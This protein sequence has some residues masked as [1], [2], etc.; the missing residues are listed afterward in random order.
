MTDTVIQPGG[1]A[2]VGSSAA[3][4]SAPAPEPSVYTDGTTIAGNGTAGDRLRALGGGHAMLTVQL[5]NGEATTVLPG[6]AVTTI[7]GMARLASAALGGTA[8]ATVTGLVVSGAGPTLP[9]T[10]ALVGGLAL[11]TAQWDAVTGQVGGLTPDAAY[12]LDTGGMLTTTP[13]TIPGASVV[14]LGRALSPMVMSLAP[15]IPV[16]L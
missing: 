14:E 13:P 9:I 12:Y 2:G 7:A 10:I 5:A 11:S 4:T 1:R 3:T 15:L 8:F 16:L 6:Q